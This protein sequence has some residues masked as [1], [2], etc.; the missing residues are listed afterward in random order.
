VPRTSLEP[1]NIFIGIN[2]SGKSSFIQGIQFAISSCQ[3]LKI[4]NI[5]FW[6]RVTESQTSALDSTDYLYTPTRHIENLYHGKRLVGSRKKADRISMSFSFD[7]G[8]ISTINVSGGKNGGFTT[9]L[10]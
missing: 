7:D 4:K 2:N 8:N 1:I 3:T 5:F 9:T 10:S 6:Q